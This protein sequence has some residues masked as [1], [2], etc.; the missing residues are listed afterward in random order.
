LDPSKTDGAD[1]IDYGILRT[2]KHPKYAGRTKEND[3]ALF[4]LNKVVEFTKFAR[5]AC[6]QVEAIEPETELVAVSDF[7]S[8]Q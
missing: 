6:L 4:K 5:P 2:I 3:I 8:Y 1:P 7:Y